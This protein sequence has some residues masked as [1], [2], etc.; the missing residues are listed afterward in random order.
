MS[1]SSSLEKNCEQFELTKLC[2]RNM[3]GKFLRH[4]TASAALAAYDVVNVTDRA[5]FF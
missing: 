2:V 1:F 3:G 5:N 4:P